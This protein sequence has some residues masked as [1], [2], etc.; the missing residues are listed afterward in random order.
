MGLRV[1]AIAIL[2]EEGGVG[3]QTLMGN[4]SGDFS[5]LAS[6]AFLCPFVPQHGGSAISKV[7]LRSRAQFYQG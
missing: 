6:L 7:G 4:V 5:F 1:C 2:R 3:H